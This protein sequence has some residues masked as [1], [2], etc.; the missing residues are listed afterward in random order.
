MTNEVEHK[1]T[2]GDLFHKLN[3]DINSS[4]GDSFS[5]YGD[6]FQYAAMFFALRLNKASSNFVN[7]WYSFMKDNPEF[8]RVEISQIANHPNFVN[9]RHD[10]SVFSLMLKIYSS[11][12]LRLR[13]LTNKDI[14]NGR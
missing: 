9:N 8:C 14:Q 2:T 11:Q 12:S 3:L 13:T 10:Q 5:S 1:W 4:Y 6:S 7:N